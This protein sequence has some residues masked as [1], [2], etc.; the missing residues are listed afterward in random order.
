LEWE[1][2][3]GRTSHTLELQELG[4][5]IRSHFGSRLQLNLLPEGLEL[6]ERKEARI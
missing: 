4:G 3:I 6:L 2:G 1:E 5:Y